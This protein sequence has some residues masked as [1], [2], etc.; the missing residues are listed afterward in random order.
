MHVLTHILGYQGVPGPGPT[1]GH[2]LARSWYW[3]H[4]RSD[5]G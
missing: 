4:G 2:L 1:R 5:G 3:E